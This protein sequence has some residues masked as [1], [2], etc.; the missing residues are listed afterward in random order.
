MK[1]FLGIWGLVGLFLGCMAA[2]ERR[3]MRQGPNS[4]TNIEEQVW[5]V[6]N[7]EGHKRVI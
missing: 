2:H 5:A 4:V 7:K 1:I 3:L 6:L